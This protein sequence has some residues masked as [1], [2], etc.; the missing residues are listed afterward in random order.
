MKQRIANQIQY[1]LDEND[2]YQALA[3]SVKAEFHER[4]PEM[5]NFVESPLYKSIVS[6][7]KSSNPKN[8]GTTVASMMALWNKNNQN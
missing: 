4:W 5:M 8:L 7:L 1:F 3:P 2:K 6:I